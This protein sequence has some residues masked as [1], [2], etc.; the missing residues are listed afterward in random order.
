ME[1]KRGKSKWNPDKTKKLQNK[2]LDGSKLHGVFFLFLLVLL[3]SVHGQEINEMAQGKF[4][5]SRIL[6]IF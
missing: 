4:F 5:Y 2:S 6:E 3:S 1:S